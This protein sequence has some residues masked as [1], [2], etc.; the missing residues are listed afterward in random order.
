MYI[1]HLESTDLFKSMKIKNILVTA[2]VPFLALFMQLTPSASAQP[3]SKCVVEI[4]GSRQGSQVN[5]RLGPGSEF[6]RT[7]YLLVGQFANLL[8][9]NEGGHIKHENNGYTWFYV[10]YQPSGFKGWIREDFID[11]TSSCGD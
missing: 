8:I 4:V 7:G 1:S 10:Q 3:V 9:D 5:L 11:F 2:I 6:E